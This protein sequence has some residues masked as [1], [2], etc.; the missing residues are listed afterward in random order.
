MQRIKG[1]YYAG[2]QADHTL[3]GGREKDYQSPILAGLT[4]RA[5]VV[6]YAPS[7]RERTMQSPPAGLKVCDK[8]TS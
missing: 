1:T 2:K 3:G 8:L 5:V 7:C 4:D 6:D